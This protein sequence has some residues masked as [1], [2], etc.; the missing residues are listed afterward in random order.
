[1]IQYA[2]E[3]TKSIEFLGEKWPA[4]SR[5]RSSR[6]YNIKITG[7]SLYTNLYTGLH[8]GVVAIADITRQQICSDHG[9]VTNTITRYK[10]LIRGLLTVSSWP[11]RKGPAAAPKLPCHRQSILVE[12]LLPSEHSII[13]IPP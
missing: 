4:L 3:S 6:K 11:A 2:E 12:L 10:I 8:I 13:C 1:M 7:C 5:D 9:T